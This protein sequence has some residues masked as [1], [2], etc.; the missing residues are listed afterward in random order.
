VAS[1]ETPKVVVNQFE[2]KLRQQYPHINVDKL[3]KAQLLLP[4]NYN[5]EITKTVLKVLQ[6]KTE[7]VQTNP[8]K[9]NVY[10]VSL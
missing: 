4:Q 5:Y 8:D 3:L 7:Y 10:K 2:A 1:S 9:T 6:A